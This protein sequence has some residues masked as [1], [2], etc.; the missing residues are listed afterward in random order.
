MPAMPR[1]HLWT[2]FLVLTLVLPQ[3]AGCSSPPAPSKVTVEERAF[4]LQVPRDWFPAKFDQ[5]AKAYV[6]D[7][8]HQVGVLK[9]EGFILY[10]SP[11]GDY[12]YLEFDPPGH[13]LEYDLEWTVEPKDDRFV[14]VKEGPFCTPPPKDF[15]G[16]DTCR[17]GDGAL[18]IQVAPW[19]LE[20]RGHHYFLQFGNVRREKDAE[21]QVFRDIL[22]SFRAK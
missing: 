17:T 21:L 22:A 9:P 8:G 3:L 14:L 16:M 10:A 5:E 19:R 2:P 4:S 12:L 11:S 13:G 20:L 6:P 7:K 15:Q 1:P 18:L